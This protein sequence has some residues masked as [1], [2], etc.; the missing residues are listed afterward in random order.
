MSKAGREPH[1]RHEVLRP[2]L[3]RRALPRA[4]TGCVWL[5]LA[6]ISIGP[7]II[8]AASPYQAARPVVYIIASLA[9]VLAMALLL[10]QPLLAAGYLPGLSLA[11]LRAAHHWVGGTL[12][13]LVAL[14]VGGL[15][16]TSPQDALDALLLVAPT[17]FSI[18]GVVAMWSVILTVLL[19]ALRRR[20]GF[21]LQAWKTAHNGLAVI[22]VVAT[23]VH[24]LMIEGTMGYWSK[25]LLSLAV[26]AIMAV[27]ILHFRL[28]KPLLHRR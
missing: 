22:V 27:V 11:R 10:V 1:T 16:L 24:A 14:H 19:V 5:I 2:E 3:S 17:P 20:L 25:W 28:I 4:L 6:C 12:V 26:L 21:R 15:Y 9:G 18:Y 13:G 7:V 23:V 8:A